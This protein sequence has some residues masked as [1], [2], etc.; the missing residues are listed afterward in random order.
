[1]VVI[2]F[3]VLTVLAVYAGIFSFGFGYRFADFLR[4]GRRTPEEIAR[5]EADLRY[6]AMFRMRKV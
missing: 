3:L 6:A 4:E 2:M 1:M 5:R